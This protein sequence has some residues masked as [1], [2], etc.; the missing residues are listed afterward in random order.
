MAHDVRDSVVDFVRIWSAKTGLSTAAFIGF[1]GIHAGKFFDWKA[2]YGKVNEH[3][4]HIPRD[5]WLTTDETTAILQFQ[6]QHPLDGY[7]ALTYMMLDQDVAAASPSSVY[8]V[9]SKA[10]RLQRW[11][12]TPS[13]KGTGFEQPL[14]PHQHWH[15]DITYLKLSGTFYYLCAVIDGATRYLVDW[16]IHASMEEE[17]VERL[18]QRAREDRKSV[19]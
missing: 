5:H 18:I 15:V 10:G 13:R 16:A 9:L 12:R 14:Q 8:R 7:R 6:E 19:V 2:R 4:H 3:N 1:L 11:S 17:N